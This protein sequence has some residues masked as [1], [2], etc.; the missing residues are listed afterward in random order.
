MNPLGPARGVVNGLVIGLAIW[1]LA[2][3]AGLLIVWVL[4]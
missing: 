1:G 4:S 2:L 3:G